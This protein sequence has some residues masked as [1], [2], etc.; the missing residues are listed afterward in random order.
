[1]QRKELELEIICQTCSD[2]I[3]NSSLKVLKE[4]KNQLLYARNGYRVKENK[5][6]VLQT[7]YLE[8]EINQKIDYNTLFNQNF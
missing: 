6:G 1:M 5:E 4:L 2:N 8:R 7:L 3:K